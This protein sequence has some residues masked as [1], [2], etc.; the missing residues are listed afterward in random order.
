[1]QQKAFE[2]SWQ[3]LESTLGN[4]HKRTQSLRAIKRIIYSSRDLNSYTSSARFTSDPGALTKPQLHKIYQAKCTD[5]EIPVLPEQELRFTSYCQ[6]NFQHRH[7][8]LKDSGLSLNS[9]LAIGAVLKVSN[10]AYIDLSENSLGDEGSFQLLREISNSQTIVHLDL[11]NNDIGPEGFNNLS[12]A[13]AYHPSLTSVN[14]SS[15]E[16]LHR[17]RIGSHAAKSLSLA[18]R[19]NRILQFLNLSGI[20]LA[21]GIE[22]LAQGLVGNSS[23]VFLDISNNS[24]GGRHMEALARA[25]IRT[26]LREIDLSYNKIADEGCEFLANMMVGAY[27]AACPLVKFNLACNGISHKGGSKIFHAL[28]LN[29]FIK[30]FNISGNNFNQGLSEYF[31]S[32]LADN[33]ALARLDISNCMIK[34]EA[35]QNIAEGLAKNKAL[36]TLILSG[37]KIQ[38][39]GIAYLAEGLSMNT[40]LKNLDLST[41]CIKG[42]GAVFLAKALRTNKVIE[43]VNLKDNSV[44]EEAGVLFVELTRN[45]KNLLYICLDLNPVNLKYVASIKKNVKENKKLQRKKIIPRILEEIEKIK[46]PIEA[47]AITNHAIRAKLREKSETE[48]KYKISLGSFEEVKQ[49][50]YRRLRSMKNYYTVLR[51]KNV[52]LSKTLETS[53]TDMLV[54]HI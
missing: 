5:M 28:R 10:F 16:G 2:K 49:K 18:V 26:E 23:L 37:N 46:A 53:Q 50:E 54:Y 52:D 25:I 19:T 6:S 47:Q 12:K 45:N 32:F 13:L 4:E 14:L 31:P 20:C 15:Y 43:G 44:K 41:C 9:A 21:E 38:D 40:V 51:E 34:G 33:A 3:K 29:C 27:E 24:I 35:L 36:E 7:F 17:N 48:R 39:T 1:M 22:A 8:Q 11:S 30:D 42:K